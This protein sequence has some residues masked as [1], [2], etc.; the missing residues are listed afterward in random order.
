MEPHY[1][2]T[3]FRCN[4]CHLV[5]LPPVVSS[6][7]L[8]SDYLYLSSCSST[9]LDHAENYVD[10]VTRRFGLGPHSRVVEIASNDGY[11]LQY[12]VARGIPALGVEPAENLIELARERGV[13]TRSAF[14]GT[15]YAQRL[16]AE[17][18]AADLTIANNVLAH[19][20]DLNDFVAGFAVLL[21]PEG[22]ATFEFPYLVN[23]IEQTQF[24]T[25]Y[26]EHFSYISLL[27]ARKVFA[28][29]GLRVFDVEP[30][31]THGGSLRLFV[32][33]AKAAH[34][35]QE[36]VGRLC[37]EE[38][39]RGFDR[40]E[41]Y[42]VFARDCVRVKRDLLRFL[43][44][45]AEQDKPV[46]AYGAPAKGNTLLNFCGSRTDLIEF[47]VDRN[48]LKQGRFLPGTRIPIKAPEAIL[49]RRPAYVLI[50]P[51]N[52][53]DEIVAQMSGV[54]DW[55]GRFVVPIPKLSVF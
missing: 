49:S 39:A 45:A 42:S 37:T 11:L 19:V 41:R 3:V 7:E 29:H 36:S 40:P 16:V 32:C 28:R 55:G 20:P 53:K 44:D 27:A 23:L 8:F 34:P 52:L 14:F 48:P 17:N 2:L 46:C 22:V 5:Q 10:D 21:K 54:R 38:A 30:L 31:P 9:W 6:T 4:A 35:E 51:W 12:V 33:H 25:I 1:P 15:E 26:H 24:D 43:F 50:L 13:D 18:W 47:T